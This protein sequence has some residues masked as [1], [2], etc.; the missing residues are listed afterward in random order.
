MGNTKRFDLFEG[1]NQFLHDMK[2]LLKPSQMLQII[3]S[4]FS[5]LEGRTRT[6]AHHDWMSRQLAILQ[7]SHLGRCRVANTQEGPRSL[8]DNELKRC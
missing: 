3:R 7:V 1:V 5:G 2:C 4:V 6:I 8:V